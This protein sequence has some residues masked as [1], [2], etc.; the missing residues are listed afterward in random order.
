ML[1]LY[2]K[3]FS[4]PLG[5]LSAGNDYSSHIPLASSSACLFTA[6][7][8]QK[9]AAPLGLMQQKLSPCEIPK[10]NESWAQMIF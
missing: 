2:R 7:T 8:R 3:L 6:Q 1:E 4:A 5:A 9:E 10:G